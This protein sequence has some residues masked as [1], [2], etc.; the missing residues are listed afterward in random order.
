MQRRME[1]RVGEKLFMKFYLYLKFIRIS[2]VAF[3]AL[4][5]KYLHLLLIIQFNVIVKKKDSNVN[6]GL[7]LCE[8]NINLQYQI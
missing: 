7:T 5:L 8:K 4:F 1:D 6:S 2:K 3:K